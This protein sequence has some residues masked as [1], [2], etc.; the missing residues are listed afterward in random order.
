MDNVIRGC[1][2]WFDSLNTWKTLDEVRLSD[3]ARATESFGSAA[4]N[5]EVA[6]PEGWQAMTATIKL[7]NNDPDIRGL[8][9][10]EPG[11]YTTAYYYEYLKSYRSG[12]EKGRVI[13][14]KGLIN[15]IKDDPKARMK[16][17]GIEYDFSTVVLYHDM[18]DGRS[19]HKLDYFA[20]PGSTIINGA[21]PFAGMA[22]ILAIGGL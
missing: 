7:R 18:F 11:D 15:S 8:C 13:V 3:F 4:G 2:W 22:R 21:T 19:I 5:W 6:W 1:N 14:L 20:G 16:A 12:E 10:K 17:S 9:G